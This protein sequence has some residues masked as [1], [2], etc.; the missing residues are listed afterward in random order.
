MNIKIIKSELH[1]TATQQVAAEKDLD[2]LDRPL[3]EILE[4]DESKKETEQA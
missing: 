2:A 4:Q 3:A 1:T